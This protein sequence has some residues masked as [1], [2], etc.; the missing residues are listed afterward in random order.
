M[1]IGVK[2]TRVTGGLTRPWAKA[3]R[4]MNVIAV[5]IILF[6]V[7]FY[8]MLPYIVLLHFSLCFHASLLFVVPLNMEHVGVLTMLGV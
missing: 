7:M 6:F 2:N 3:R 5:I 8:L 1:A 4:I